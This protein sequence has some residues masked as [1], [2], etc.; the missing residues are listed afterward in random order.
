M[1]DEQEFQKM[2]AEGDRFHVS[3]F[4]DD[5]RG[6]WAVF[7]E[8]DGPIYSGESLISEWPSRKAAIEAAH[9]YAASR[10]LEVS[11]DG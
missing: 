6:R 2:V 5:M 1:F 9:A 8:A 3:I 7:L 11:V 10:G 4:H